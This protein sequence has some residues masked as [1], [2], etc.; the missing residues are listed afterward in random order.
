MHQV[1]LRHTQDEEGFNDKGQKEMRQ[2]GSDRFNDKGQPVLETRQNG[3]QHE[4]YGT[5][6]VSDL[7]IAQMR[8]RTAPGEG[9]RAV[10]RWKDENDG[11]DPDFDAI[12]GEMAD[13]KMTAMLKGLEANGVKVTQDAPDLGQA[14]FSVTQAGNARLQV[15][16]AEAFRDDGHRVSSTFQAIAHA[17]LYNEAKRV[18]DKAPDDQPDQAAE[19]RVAAYKLSPSKQADSPAFAEA[20]LVASHVAVHE[21][22]A[23]GVTYNP[24]PSVANGDMQERWA[25]KFEEPGGLADVSRQ[26]TRT[27]KL[28]EELLPS[29]TQGRYQ[30]REQLAGHEHA[31]RSASDVAARAASGLRR[32]LRAGGDPAVEGPADRPDA[33]AKGDDTTR[34]R[35]QQQDH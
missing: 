17:N 22:T 15:P 29:R 20:E 13:R 8:D 27:V 31:G 4:T 12:R 33:P 6:H 10:Q 34:K 28:D 3:R 32:D 7:N 35:T 11:R 26:I 5:Y 9:G 19:S 18:A 14:R 1:H 23:L 25:R 30:T 16:P 2:A 24:P 21:T